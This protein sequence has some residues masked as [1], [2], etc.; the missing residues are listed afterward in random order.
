MSFLA[1]LIHKKQTA[2]EVGEWLTELIDSP[3][4]ADR[5]SQTGADIVNL[6][7]DYDR[8][9][10]LPQALVEEL[11]KLSVLGQQLWVEARKA[12]DYARFQP[13]LKRTLELKRQEAAAI[14]YDDQPYD[15]LLDE[16]EPG[17]KTS[18]VAA[19]LGGL[20][21]QLVPLVAA[22]AA[23]KKRP[24][25][26]ALKGRYPIDLQEKFG[27]RAIAALGF[28][29]N[30]GRLDVTNHPFCDGAGPRDV[31]LT[32][33]YDEGSLDGSFFSTLHEAGHGIYEQ[34]LPENAR[35]GVEP[36]PPDLIAQ[37][38]DGGASFD[39]FLRKEPSA[40]HRCYSEDLK[41]VRG[42]VRGANPVWV[43][44]HAGNVDRVS[45]GRR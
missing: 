33:R 7:R 25:L 23:S 37:N 20:R 14:G 17:A 5:H 12:N 22:I 45:R 31:R 1:G 44:V 27:K 32:T 34:G 42:N 30:A 39:F 21:E 6:K 43:A 8:K 26:E 29:F 16:F 35:G 28:D 9:T 10:K 38:H 15:A 36:C 4:A 18:E 41:H 19:A 40:Q 11:A 24:N 2:P 13:L 3:L